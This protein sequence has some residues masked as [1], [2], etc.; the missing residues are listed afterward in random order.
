MLRKQPEPFSSLWIHGPRGHTSGPI[1]LCLRQGDFAIFAVDAANAVEFGPRC[2][3][4]AR[5]RSMFRRLE[6]ARWIDPA[7]AI[8]VIDIERI[9]LGFVEMAGEIGQDNARMQ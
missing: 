5:C 8:L 3:P 2:C 4:D 7:I 6:I 9:D 1:R